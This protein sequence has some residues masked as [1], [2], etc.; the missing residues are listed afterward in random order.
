M[1]HR[2]PL[3][4]SSWNFT[5]TVSDLDGANTFSAGLQ[6]F[7]NSLN[8]NNNS[9]P[10]P[11]DQSQLRRKSDYEIRKQ[12]VQKMNSSALSNITSW[13]DFAIRSSVF[14]TRPLLSKIGKKEGVRVDDLFKVSEKVMDPKT[15]KLK[16]RHIGYVRAK[17]VADN[18]YRNNG[19]S[20][21]SSFYRIS[22]RRISKGMEL[23]EY[24]ETDYMFGLMYNMDS[25][26]IMG[27]YFMN[28]EYITHMIPGF[29][30][31][32]DLGYNPRLVS[33]EVYDVYD[34]VPGY[35][36]S[37]A[38]TAAFSLRQSFSYHRL[39]V[40]AIGGALMNYQ[41]LKDGT[42][43]G[44][45]YETINSSKISSEYNYVGGFSFGYLYGADVGFN[46]TRTIQ[47]RGGY[48]FTGNS[49]P[50]MKPKDA[51]KSFPYYMKYNN[52]TISVGLR[53]ARL[54]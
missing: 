39:S 33:K 8:S 52:S 7:T 51:T 34:P 6:A 29:N 35:F 18:R 4:T 2:F 53:L 37:D 46:L 19:V 49:D 41:V 15:G 11:I 27:G 42:V 3:K 44:R 47:L 50:L 12:L 28:V 13:E 25:T 1:N 31:A 36:V 22:S 14:S 10:K 43:R 45:D 54:N 30:L 16:S 17:R 40:T 26:N 38:V 23:T 48:R 32:L 24:D 5:V 9:S 20:N 21:P